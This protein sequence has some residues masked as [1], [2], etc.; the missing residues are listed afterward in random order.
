MLID[1][2]GNCK[3]ADFGSS[4]RLD[5]IRRTYVGTPLYMPPEIVLNKTHGTQADLWNLGMLI[6]ELLTGSA[7]TIV[8]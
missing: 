2:E 4:N 6:Y 7:P 1:A 3:L 5:G 8:E